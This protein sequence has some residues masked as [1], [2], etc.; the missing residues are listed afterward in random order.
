[1]LV[2]RY[3]D[4]Q[5]PISDFGL[6]I[7]NRGGFAPL[8]SLRV[9]KSTCR[10]SGPAWQPASPR[11][12]CAGDQIGSPLRGCRFFFTPSQVIAQTF[13]VTARLQPRPPLQNFQTPCLR[14]YPSWVKSAIRNPQSAIRNCCSKGLRDIFPGQNQRHRVC[15]DGALMLFGVRFLR[16]GVAEM[17]RFLLA[18]HRDGRIVGLCSGTPQAIF[19]EREIPCADR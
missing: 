18:K 19:K 3:S 15:A 14:T 8:P 11:H 1:M 10:R 16:K 13:D 9:K 6:R 5:F 12:Y 2:S 4:C 7:A 17:I